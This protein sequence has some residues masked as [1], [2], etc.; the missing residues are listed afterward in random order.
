MAIHKLRGLEYLVA[1]VEHG[2]FN[3]AARQLGVAAPS[4][5]R[6]VRALEAE[7]GLQLIDRAAQPLRPTPA[8]LVYVEKARDL[9][10]ELREL[11]ASLQD[12]AFGPRGTVTLAA[13]SVVLQFVLPA[14][15]PRFHAAFRRSSWRSSTPAANATWLGWVPT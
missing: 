10:A 2:G 12:Q 6:L 3:A 5:H 11:D 9:L 14:L 7:L 8:A 15:L 1:V 4:V 13:H